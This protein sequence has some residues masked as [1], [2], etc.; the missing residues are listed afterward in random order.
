MNV[1]KVEFDPNV[2]TL[3]LIMIMSFDFS[4]SFFSRLPKHS[5]IKEYVF[6]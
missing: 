5:H 6:I 1:L 3:R 4:A 2:F